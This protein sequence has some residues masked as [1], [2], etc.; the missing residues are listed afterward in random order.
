MFEE[1][2]VVRR[3]VLPLAPF[4]VEHAAPEP[5]A[6]NPHPALNVEVN[7]MTFSPDDLFVAVGRSD[8]RTHVYD[9]RFLNR[10]VHEYRHERLH[11][12]HRSHTF[13]GVVG[14]QWVQSASAGSR[15]G[16]VTGGNDGCVR[17][18]NPLYAAGR[19][20]T[21]VLAQ[22]DLDIAAFSLGDR[23]QGEHELVVGDSAGNISIH[24]GHPL[25]DL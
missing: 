8:N 16:L 19:E 18:W 11:L 20:T 13:Y 7:C 6:E 1:R 5:S 12:R 23:F 10:V 9:V 2:T 25:P 3:T 4:D 22:A 15:L 14:L 24:D 21:W 17:L